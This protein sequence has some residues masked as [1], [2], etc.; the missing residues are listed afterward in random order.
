MTARLLFAD[1][2]L[3]ALDKPAGLSLATPP[4]DPGAAVRRLV[5]A[6]PAA[7]RREEALDPDALH[8]VHR[9]D[10]GTTGVVLLARDAATHRALA[11]ALGGRRIGKLYLALC[12]GHPR[13]RDGRYDAP[14]G[15]DRADRR[16]MRV[17]PA[18]RPA[19]TRYRV[20]AA[21]P[22]AALVELRP[23]T[24]RTH[25]IRVHLAQAGHPIVGDDFYG[26]PRHRGVRDAVL[27]AAL[28]PDHTFLHAWRLE[29]PDE[30]GPVI[31]APLPADFA[32]ALDL[33]RVSPPALLPGVRPRPANRP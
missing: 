12:W 16:K 11:A 2:R 25:Q 4:R 26:G 32:A 8:L 6:L 27:R 1:E 7:V 15:P 5:E 3:V 20:L 31:T 24:G 9:L 18:G 10:V 13:P 33:L 22:H 17:D 21:P 19:A 29:L 23:E 30:L 14:L 28:A